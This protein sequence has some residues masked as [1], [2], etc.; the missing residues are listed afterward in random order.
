MSLSTHVAA[1]HFSKFQGDKS[2]KWLPT[3]FKFKLKGFFYSLLIFI[4]CS[5]ILY[6]QRGNLTSWIISIINPSFL[7]PLVGDW[8]LNEWLPHFLYG[9]LSLLIASF[10]YSLRSTLH[11]RQ[12]P[13][14]LSEAMK[15]ADTLN[16]NIKAVNE[17][18]FNFFKFFEP[19]YNEAGLVVRMDEVGLISLRAAQNDISQE[20]KREDAEAEE[21]KK[22]TEKL[23]KE[24]A[25]KQ[26]ELEALTEE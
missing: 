9:P 2:L 7:W 6:N 17:N 19:V 21:K 20:K 8:Q 25:Q 24:L 26:K 4:A 1:V 16:E 14:K 23:T 10:Y 13:E 3:D 18:L 11:Q 22:K 12:A 15:R 5:T